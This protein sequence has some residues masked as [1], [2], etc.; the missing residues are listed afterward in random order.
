MSRFKKL[1]KSIWHCKYHIVWVP[2]YRLQILTGEV[3][4]EI[5]KCIRAFQSNLKAKLLN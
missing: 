1:S 4:V 2:K 3:A 5:A